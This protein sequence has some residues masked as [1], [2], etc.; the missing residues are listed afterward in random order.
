M[1]AGEEVQA[2]MPWNPKSCTQICSGYATE[3]IGKS[4]QY[5][6]DCLHSKLM[7]LHCLQEHL[8]HPIAQNVC[9]AYGLDAEAA[10]IESL[11]VLGLEKLACRGTRGSV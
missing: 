8:I 4:V 11:I 7:P 9:I 2:S 10:R 6:V 5:V 3:Q 1:R